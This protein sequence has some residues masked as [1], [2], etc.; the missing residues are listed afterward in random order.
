M[1]RL[2]QKEDPLMEIILG[3]KGSLKF[4]YADIDEKARFADG[5][6]KRLKAKPTNEWKLSQI[7]NVCYVL[8]VPIET[9]R[10]S[11]SYV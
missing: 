10:R 3:R 7:M 1:P 4:T 5:T 8:D 9:V 6:F 11:I 2:K